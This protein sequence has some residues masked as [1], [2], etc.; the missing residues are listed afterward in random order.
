M[1]LGNFGLIAGGAGGGRG[2]RYLWSG[3]KV[4]TAAAKIIESDLLLLPVC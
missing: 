4:C 2:L 1:S 3:S